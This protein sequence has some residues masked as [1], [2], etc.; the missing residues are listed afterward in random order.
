MHDLAREQVCD[1]GEADV[2]VRPHVDG[3]RKTG[4]ELFG[5]DVIEEDERPDHVTARERQD[6]PDFESPEI[7]APLIDDFHA[8]WFNR[9]AGAGARMVSGTV[10]QV[11]RLTPFPS[12][13]KDFRYSA[14]SLLFAADKPN[15]KCE[16]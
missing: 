11:R 6:T 1:R 5:P 15:E 12:F 7:P 4:R 9:P 10:F 8:G 13:H 2:G 3:F 16:S 14:R